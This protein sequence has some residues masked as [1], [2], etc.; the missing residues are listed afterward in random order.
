VSATATDDEK[1]AAV[2]WE[3]WRL[4]DP[5]E[6]KTD[7]DAQ[8]AE[9]NPAVGGPSLPMYKGDYQSAR[10]AFAMPYYTLPLKNYTAFLDGIT[11]GTVKLQVEPTPAGQDYY[12]AV[13]AVISSILTDQSVDPA[14]ALKD[15]AAT[16]QT[17][18]LD[19]LST[20]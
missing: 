19:R 10:F 4:F 6:I 5:T 14:A 3:L 15:A 20:K 2:Y 9:D 1:E 17:T 7:L 16:F 8:K 13:G 12:S 18:A 11:A